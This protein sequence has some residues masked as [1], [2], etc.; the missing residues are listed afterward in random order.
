M[1]ETSK[2]F[3][4]KWNCNLKEKETKCRDLLLEEYC[5]KLFSLMDSFWVE[6]SGKRF[7][8]CWLARVRGHLDKV[9]KEQ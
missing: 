9:E 6:I 2:E 3:Q 8:I 1:G 5:S 4:K 7:D